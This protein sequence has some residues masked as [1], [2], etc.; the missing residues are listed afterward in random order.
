MKGLAYGASIYEDV[1][2]GLVYFSIYK[3]PDSA[4]AFEAAKRVITNLA[5]GKVSG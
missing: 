2:K 3:S 1:E 4:K 5:E